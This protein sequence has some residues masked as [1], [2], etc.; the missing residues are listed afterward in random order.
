MS[1]VQFKVF[2]F[3][4]IPNTD[5]LTNPNTLQY[6]NLKIII[7]IKL[8]DNFFDEIMAPKKEPYMGLWF[9]EHHVILNRRMVGCYTHTHTHTHIYPKL[10]ENLI[11][12]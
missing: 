8:W 3:Y 1:C 10:R 6:T 11:K 4:L 7:I 5:G 9:H 2:F 12:F